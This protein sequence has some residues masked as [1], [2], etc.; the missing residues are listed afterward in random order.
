MDS[1]TKY[2]SLWNKILETIGVRVG[3]V[4]TGD[5]VLPPP[6]PSKNGFFLTN[7]ESDFTRV[8]ESNWEKEMFPTPWLPLVFDGVSYNRDPT[9]VHDELGGA[10]VSI[11][12]FYSK[13]LGFVLR[14][15]KST[16][17]GTDVQVTQLFAE[18]TKR[19]NR[20]SSYYSST[21]LKILKYTEYS[22]RGVPIQPDETSVFSTEWQ[23]FVE[24]SYSET[25]INNGITE[26][27]QTIVG[28]LREKLR[29]NS[30]TQAH[31]EGN[32]G[33]YKQLA[34]ITSPPIHA[35]GLEFYNP[36]IELVFFSEADFSLLHNR[37]KEGNG[38]PKS[39]VGK[40]GP[41]YVDIFFSGAIIN[42]GQVAAGRSQIELIAGKKGD[43]PTSSD[44]TLKAEA[45]Y[46]KNHGW[47]TGGSSARSAFAD[48]EYVPSKDMND[49]TSP[50][51]LPL[52]VLGL[53]CPKIWEINEE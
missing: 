25:R 1:S 44:F 24:A 46:R 26:S 8:F 22:M 41:H 11:N 19:R 38:D 5:G 37:L 35:T 39:G 45:V 52:V 10:E 15:V 31:V 36:N 29:D 17:G 2:N 47:G 23:K 21:Y 51:P 33:V 49:G 9:L 12:K 42:I 7:L 53:P 27:T 4:R 40:I 6:V 3:K 43:Y 13:R 34:D 50:P 16:T 30:I 20:I 18:I 28:G 32:G 48:R 14:L